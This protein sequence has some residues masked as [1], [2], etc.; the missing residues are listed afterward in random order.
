MYHSSRRRRRRRR[1]S[2]LENMCSK[3]ANHITSSNLD[4]ISDIWDHPIELDNSQIKNFLIGSLLHR[5]KTCVC[6][7]LTFTC[8]SMSGS[9]THPHLGM[10][11]KTSNLNDF[12]SPITAAVA[13]LES[14]HRALQV[15]HTKLSKLSG[16]RPP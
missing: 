13:Y 10:E 12:S 4:G 2:T 1:F 16:L 9:T 7:I 6:S 5:E 11:I 3:L 8:L 14:L 15:S